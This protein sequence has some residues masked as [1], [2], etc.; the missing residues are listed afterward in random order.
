MEQ[1]AQPWG[2]E[3]Q[4]LLGQYY[5]HRSSQPEGIASSEASGLPQE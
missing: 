2:S 4:Q 1:L 3:Q 5:N